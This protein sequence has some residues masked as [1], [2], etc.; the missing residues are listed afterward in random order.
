MNRSSLDSLS[1]AEIAQ[2]LGIRTPSL[3]SHFAS[4]QDLKD[5]LTLR[6]L[7]LFQEDLKASLIQHQEKNALLAFMKAYR[8]FARKHPLLFNATQFG[9][10]TQD[11]R[12]HAEAEKIVL[13]AIEA[14]QSTCKI[15]K[16]HLI[17]AVRTLR[18]L[19]N[20]FI[21]LEN[22]GG[23]Q[24]KEKVDASFEALLKFTMAGLS[25]FERG[26]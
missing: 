21:N 18:S 25:A 16:P 1:M 6:A 24:R 2:S 22:E 10:R 3:Y 20:G 14:L 9:I 8:A 17:D 23:F 5:Q 19:L 13:L 7:L 26:Q 4:L 11:P 15:S 12:I